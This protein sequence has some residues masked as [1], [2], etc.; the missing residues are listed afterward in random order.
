[1]WACMQHRRY[2]FAYVWWVYC[3]WS[4][5]SVSLQCPLPEQ[6]VIRLLFSARSYVSTS[7]EPHGLQLRKSL[8]STAQ[9]SLS[10]PVLPPCPNLFP[11]SDPFRVSVRRQSIGAS[12]LAS[13]CE[14]SRKIALHKWSPAVF[15]NTRDSKLTLSIT[16]GQLL[17]LHW[18][19]IADCYGQ[20]FQKINGQNLTHIRFWVGNM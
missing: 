12:N 19:I 13:I 8:G 9:M 18:K 6:E 20:E 11:A 10:W 17:R 14:H 7:L 4:T 16:A 1:M 2:M 5:L 15:F 3:I